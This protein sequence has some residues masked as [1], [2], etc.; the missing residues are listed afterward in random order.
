MGALR[1]GSRSARVGA[2]Q[3]IRA[4]YSLTEV[5][6]IFG[7][8]V[9]CRYTHA[10]AMSIANMIML[11]VRL[12]ACVFVYEVCQYAA[13]RG[14]SQ[15]ICIVYVVQGVSSKIFHTETGL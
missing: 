5:L 14:L 2:T 6:F 12:A 7:M 13:M 3:G 1:K 10:D 8:C 4:R 11:E 9:C 15:A